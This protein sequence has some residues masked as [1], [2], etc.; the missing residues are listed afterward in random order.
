MEFSSA[1]T[2]GIKWHV[3]CF[4]SCLSLNVVYHLV[5]FFCKKESYT[6][7]T[8]VLRDRMNNHITACRHGN[9]TDKFDNHVY[10]CAKVLNVPLIE[11]YFQLYVFL[12]ISDYTR[13]RN[14]E[15]SFHTRGYDTM[16]K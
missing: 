16:N 15:K 11:P 2:K 6:G 12:T 4:I 5:C 14:Y 3:K 7:K 8:D 1:Q 10:N 13:L 9:T